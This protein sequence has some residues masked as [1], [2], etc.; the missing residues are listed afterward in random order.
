MNNH[1]L[2]NE[3]AKLV[4][5]RG[6]QIAYAIQ[7]GYL[8]EPEMRLTHQRIFT[9]QDI[10]RIREYFATKSSNRGKPSKYGSTITPKGGSD[11]VG[12]T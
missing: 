10:V 9:D 6:Y 12:T 1:Y 8:P 5:V 2:L 3:A 11:E 7:Q 4:G